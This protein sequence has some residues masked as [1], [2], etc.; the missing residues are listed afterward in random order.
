MRPGRQGVELARIGQGLREIGIQ[1]EGEIRLVD[2]PAA[3]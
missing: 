3:S 2:L 1:A